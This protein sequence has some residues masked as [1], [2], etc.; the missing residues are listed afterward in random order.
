MTPLPVI[1][2][3]YRVALN[4]SNDTP[5]QSAENVMHFHAV[6]SSAAAVGAVL[7]AN[8]VNDMWKPVC[9]TSGVDSLSITPLDGSS[10][11]VL[12]TTESSNWTGETE[13]DWSP[14][15]APVVAFSTG[16]RGR[17]YRGRLF[18]PFCAEGAIS[19]G[20]LTGALAADVQD[21]W[22]AFAGDLSVTAV[23]H[24][25]AS[26]KHASATAV[27][28]YTVASAIGTQRRRQTRVRYP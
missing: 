21:A 1:A 6:G 13:G 27:T 28:A 22:I 24:V 8:V 14:A 23:S 26:Y 19:D 12:F 18:L 25:V 2:D 17:S 3:V 20:A 10:A 7:D 4:W 9:S 5:G 16:L 15:S 11:T